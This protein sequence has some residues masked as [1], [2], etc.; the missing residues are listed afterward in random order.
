M[1]GLNLGGIMGALVE[2][3][4]LEA[5]I[6]DCCYAIYNATDVKLAMN[7]WVRLRELLAEKTDEETLQFIREN[8]PGFQPH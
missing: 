2:G 1:A 7:K 3:R 5:E 8:K 4:S 6:V